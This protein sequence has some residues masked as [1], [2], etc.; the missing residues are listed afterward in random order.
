MPG[1]AGHGNY[2]IAESDGA[3]MRRARLRSPPPVR[4]TPLHTQKRGHRSI[5][6]S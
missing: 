1:C 3:T 2:T 4:E 6:D 5:V